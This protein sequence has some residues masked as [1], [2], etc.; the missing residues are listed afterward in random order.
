MLK[1]HSN[2]IRCVL[3]LFRLRNRLADSNIFDN[4]MNNSRMACEYVEFTLRN[5]NLDGCL[6]WDTLF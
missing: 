4:L 1:F 3:L 5:L 2:A 6:G